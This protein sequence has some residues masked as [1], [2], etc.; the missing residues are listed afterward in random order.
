MSKIVSPYPPPPRP[1][2]ENPPPAGASWWRLELTETDDGDN[3]M[4]VET[5]GTQPPYSQDATRISWESQDATW[6]SWEFFD[7]QT[8]ILDAG[9]DKPTVFEAWFRRRAM[10]V[11]YGNPRRRPGEMP[12]EYGMFLDLLTVGPP[13]P[14]KAWQA[15]TEPGDWTHPDDR[16][17]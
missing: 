13:T 12:I 1:T 11:Q 15:L 17:D 2:T 4:T 14:S 9:F 6:I 3:I 5:D 16:D 10:M 7:G 8:A